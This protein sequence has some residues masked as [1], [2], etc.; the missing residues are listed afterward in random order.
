MSNESGGETRLSGGL[1]PP[2]Q[3]GKNPDNT[4]YSATLHIRD[5][6]FVKKL[7]SCMLIK[8]H[9]AI[10]NLLFRLTGLALAFLP[11][12][13]NKTTLLARRESVF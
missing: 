8:L 2:N 7:H 5:L 4:T 13:W 9:Q 6:S 11:F 1:I 3:H 10:L 12:A